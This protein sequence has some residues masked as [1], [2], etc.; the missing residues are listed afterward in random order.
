MSK[1]S[2]R[3]YIETRMKTQFGSAKPAIKIGYPNSNF[4]PPEN[5]LYGELHILGGRTI[6]A[7]GS[8]GQQVVDR[9]T[10]IVQ[11]TFYSPNESGAAEAGKLADIVAKIFRHSKG[12]TD[13]G[14]VVTFKSAE[15]PNT[16]KLAGF[17][18]TIVKIPFYRDEFVT[19]ST[20]A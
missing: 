7:G 1:D 9:H 20:S 3:V 10:G 8:N 11:V 16:G 6:V 12:R 18:A 4:K 2:E 19:V 13:A 14:D 17:H 5:E 15:F